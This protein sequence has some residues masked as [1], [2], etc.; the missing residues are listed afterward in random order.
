[1]AVVGYL[2]RWYFASNCLFFIVVVASSFDYY[3]I[4][5]HID[6]KKTCFEPFSLET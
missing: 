3:S 5:F 4:F 2:V 6:S 1:M